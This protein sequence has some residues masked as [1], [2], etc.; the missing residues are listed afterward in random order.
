ML[1]NIGVTRT[2]AAARYIHGTLKNVSMGITNLMGPVEPMT[3]ANHPVT[4]LYFMVV[5]A[6]HVCQN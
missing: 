4:G 5:G 6:P 3:L 2:Q 1:I